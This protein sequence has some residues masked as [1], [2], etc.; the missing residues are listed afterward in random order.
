MKHKG[1]ITP[2]A[3]GDK[4]WIRVRLALTLAVDKWEMGWGEIL[5]VWY[6][7]RAESDNGIYMHLLLFY[8]PYQEKVMNGNCERGCD[9][10]LIQRS[11]VELVEG[12]SLT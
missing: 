6:S 12:G 11:R 9:R 8:Y 10:K 2:E 3:R 7:W 4:Q 1:K 5:W